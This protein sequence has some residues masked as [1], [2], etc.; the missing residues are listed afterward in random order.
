MFRDARPLVRQENIMTIVQKAAALALAY[1][2]LGACATN[3]SAVRVD[4]ADTDLAKCQTFDWLQPTNSTASLTDQRIR[5]AA[6]AELESKGYTLETDDPDCRISY[7]LSTFERPQAKPRV[8][9][10]AGGGSGGIGGGIGVSLPVGRRDT[11][12]GTLTID[13]IDVDSNA[14]VWSGT[15]DASFAA[16][17]LNEDEARATVNKILAEFPNRK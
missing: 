9:V 4:R 13:I 15:L 12:G 16:A 1:L 11:H 7:V 17:E 8:G 14:Q 3:S 5:A 2:L 6:L 10:G